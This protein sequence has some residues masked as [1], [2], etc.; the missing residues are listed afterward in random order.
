MTSSPHLVAW[1]PCL[2]HSTAGTISY[3]KGNGAQ[4]VK[5]KNS[6][7]AVVSESNSPEASHSSTEEDVQREWQGVVKRRSFLKGLGIAGAVLSAGTLLATEGAAHTSSGAAKLSKGDIALLQFA[8]WAEIVESDLGTQYAELGGV[9]PSGGGAAQA[10]EEFQKFIGGN[11][12]YNL[13]LQNL[14]GDMPQYITD[15]T[16]DELSHAA[17]LKAFLKSRG[18]VPVDLEPF[19][20]LPSSKATGARQIKRITN[21]MNLNVDL[22]WY[23]RYRSGKNPDLGEAFKGPFVIANQP[24]IPLNDT[25]TPPSTNPTIPITGRDAERIQAIANT[26]GFHFAF[27]ERGGA[28]LY[29]TLAFKATDPTVLRILVSI[30]GVEIDHFGLWHD[31][32]GNAVAQPLAGVVDPVTGLTFPDLNNPATELTQTNKILPEPC[33]FISKSLPPCSVIRPTLT[34]N[35]GAVATIKA[36]TDDLLFLGQSPAFFS[37]VNQLAVEADSVRRGF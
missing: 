8:A 25:D 26:A 9:G 2:T 6:P 31:K 15:N 3:A 10:S 17:F 22:S 16:D 28:S 18:V 36:F 23:T 32:G 34:Q 27:I 1:S 11:P 29:P 5:E 30:G 37:L 19:R 20:K 14:D 35:G 24:A 21:L 4:T 33:E 13:A 12:A 7:S